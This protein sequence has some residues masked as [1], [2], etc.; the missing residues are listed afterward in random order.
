MTTRKVTGSAIQLRRRILAMLPQVQQQS[1]VA[2]VTAKHT[3]GSRTPQTCAPDNQATESILFHAAF[4]LFFAKLHALDCRSFSG[5][6]QYKALVA[7]ILG[8]GQFD[9]FRVSFS[10]IVLKIRYLFEL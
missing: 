7:Y 6:T 8:S 1:L 9:E 2:A 3:I 10:F 4:K 5:L